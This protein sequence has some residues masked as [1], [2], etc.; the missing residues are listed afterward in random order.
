V[1]DLRWRRLGLLFV[2]ALAVRV[3]TAWLLRQPGYTDAYYYAVGARQLYSGQGFSEPFIWN[4]VAP[5]TS[6]PHAGYLY[7]MPLAAIMGWL[8]MVALGSS[9][10]A[11]QA[12]FIFTSALLPLVTYVVALDLTVKPKHAL[13]A[14]LLAVFPGFFAAGFVLP[15]TFAP[16]ALAGSVCLLAAGQGLRSRRPGWF[17]LA[18]LA[19]GLGHLAR[20]DGLLLAAVALLAAALSGT[21]WHRS[22]LSAAG[23]VHGS[24][25]PNDGPTAAR[26]RRKVCMPLLSVVLVIAGYLLV[27]GAWLVRNW[28]AFGSPLPGAG[29]RTAFLT[30]YDD[31][32]AFDGSL[33]L[34]DYLSWG[35]SSILGS[36]WDA[37]LLNLQR[38]WIECLLV[39]LP[40]FAALGLWH[41]RKNRLLW[42]F[43][44]YAPLLFLAMTFAF[45][46]PGM[47]GGLYHS[48][49][50][51]LPFLFAATG[52]GLE[53]ALRWAAGRF[54]GWHLRTAWPV[55]STAIVA[56]AVLMTLFGL[57]RSGALSGDW[58]ER[59]QQYAQIGGW[60][61][62]E[63]AR[64]AIVM[65]GD[66][67]AFTWFTGHP[68]LAVPND[69]LDTILAV[70][71]QYGACYLVLNG[72][73]PRTTD[74]LY[75][76]KAGDPRL[77]L[78]L[79]GGEEGQRWQLYEI[80]GTH[81]P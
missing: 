78:R 65:V 1:K 49:A 16:F 80:I 39:V 34:Q 13:L 31:M 29:T 47:R 20:A 46:F 58:N 79:D 22:D 24:P 71:D 14:G 37:L 23:G 25:A 7:W 40:P 74:A 17:A 77:V 10:W 72:T 4:Y 44:L 67:P 27:M 52:P 60:L 54:R 64:E 2:L 33:T 69:P 15:E 32:F 36:K 19:A 42:P 18:G 41:S 61:E 21:E 53:V 76:G 73:R 63:G 8:G 50:A 68:A 59:G 43:F 11:V 6:L 38:V 48:S 81:G 51:W 57:W 56:M 75:A 70:A 26:A 55:F 9:F 5:P 62:Q 12:P 30:A 45:T 3:L 35:W 28:Q 66:A